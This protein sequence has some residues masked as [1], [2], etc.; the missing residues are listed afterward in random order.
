MLSY[1]ISGV[2]ICL[3]YRFF[4]GPHRSGGDLANP[5]KERWPRGQ[6]LHDLVT[7]EVKDLL[8]K[9]HIPLLACGPVK[10]K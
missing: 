1:I 9:S 4:F 2:K 8:M 3:L 6:M 5:V 7:H 10:S